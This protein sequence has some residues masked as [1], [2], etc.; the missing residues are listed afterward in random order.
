MRPLLVL[1]IVAL[2]DCG[3]VFAQSAKT[4]EP[5]PDLALTAV[6]RQHHA[7]STESGQAQTISIRELHYSMDLIM[8]K[9]RGHSG[10]P[11]NLIHPRRCLCGASPWLSARITT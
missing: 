11:V 8:K 4:P 9:L 2:L 1:L 10:A 5:P 3:N 6:G 7:I